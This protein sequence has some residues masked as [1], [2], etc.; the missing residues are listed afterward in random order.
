[1]RPINQT[2][3]L[4]ANNIM[5]HGYHV[6]VVSGGAVPRWVYTI[7]LSQSLGYELVLAG[8]GALLKDSVLGLISAL[9][10]GGEWQRTQTFADECGQFAISPVCEAWKADL[11]AGANDYY[12]RKV[13]AV[14]IVPLGAL[15][16]IDVPD[17]AF[18]YTR[19]TPSAWRWLF[20]PWPY[21]NVP[22][23]SEAMVDAHVLHGVPATEAARWE[24]D[25]WEVFSSRVEQVAKEDA[26]LIPLGALI[27][28]DPSLEVFSSLSVGQAIQRGSNGEGWRD[29]DR[30]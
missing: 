19:G 28:S 27:G 13:D 25:Y 7:G 2:R 9:S 15:A 10:S 30:G 24:E 1:M 18:E 11:L 4:I 26:R 5:R 12:S 22:K 21:P 17:L 6:Y 3:E 23:N 8:G 16:T 14:Q 29:L 20:E